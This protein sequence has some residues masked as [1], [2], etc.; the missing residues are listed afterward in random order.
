MLTQALLRE[1]IHYDPSTGAF[2]W[3]ARDRKWFGSDRMWRCTNT[4]LCGERAGSDDGNGYTRIR[5]L[6]VAYRGHRLAWLYVH[7]RWPRH[8]I[9]HI[10]HNPRNDAIA[11]LREAT[12]GVNLRNQAMRKTNTSGHTG[13]YW[14]TR[15]LK[16]VSEILV[17]GRKIHLGS[18]ALKPDAISARKKA[19]RLH[20]FHENHGKSREQDDSYQRAN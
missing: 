1:L 5:I 14:S 6:G 10:D 17:Q 9:D 7:G 18:F 12:H 13:V 8:E 4:R 3:K 19:E 2:T 16:W 15:R 11:N 20:G